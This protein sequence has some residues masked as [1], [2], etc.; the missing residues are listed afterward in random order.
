MA[1]Q[2]HV[3]K[4][5]AHS[6]QETR[7]CDPA[8]SKPTVAPDSQPPPA[9]RKRK[10]GVPS[11]E[12]HTTQSTSSNRSSPQSKR[13]KT[14]SNSSLNSSTCTSSTGFSW[15]SWARAETEYWDSLPRIYLT[16]DCL[17]EHNRRNKL[18]LVEDPSNE[19][20]KIN[21]EQ[22]PRDITRFARHGGPDL[23]DIRNV[24]YLYPDGRTLH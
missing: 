6:R 14:S 21:F 12:H 15:S 22:H 2:Q 17:R 9:T 5:G 18:L 8:S 24:R 16:S 19:G 10:R 13:Q 23:S 4:V 1:I 20:I 3:R 7:P 11:P